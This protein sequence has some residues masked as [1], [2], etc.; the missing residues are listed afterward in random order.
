MT[1]PV[2]RYGCFN[3]APFKKT[4]VVPDGHF[5]DGVT[6]VQKMQTIPFTMSMQCEYARDPMGYG[7]KDERCVGCKWRADA[8]NA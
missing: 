4:L 7:Q 5:M 8:A 6:R 3:R 1:E 2:R